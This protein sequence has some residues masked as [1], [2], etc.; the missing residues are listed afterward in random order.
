MCLLNPARKPLRR[1]RA[2][3]RIELSLLLLLSAAVACA[4]ANPLPSPGGGNPLPGPG[5]S[6]VGPPNRPDIPDPGQGTG[7]P[8][9]VK[10]DEL[11]AHLNRGLTYLS[12]LGPEEAE[13][14]VVLVGAQGA[15]T[16]EGVVRV[17]ADTLSEPL[18]MPT[19]GV[20]GFGGLLSQ[21]A[22]G[23]AVTLELWAVDDE[24]GEEEQKDSFVLEVRQLDRTEVEVPW[25]FPA[26][27]ADDPDPDASFGGWAPGEDDEDGLY[28][29]SRVNGVGVSP[30]DAS[31]MVRV[32]GGPGSVP[33]FSILIALHEE[34]SR[35]FVAQA[36][37][38]G[39]FQIT[40]AAAA[41]DTIHVF[42]AHPS[43]SAGTT[44][45]VVFVVPAEATP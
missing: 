35:S 5:T 16:G 17:A 7:S 36:V 19:N 21:V 23:T 6:E 15:A 24:S 40:L 1:G 34:S 30:P 4:E 22:A 41:G 3:H 38:D 8:P 28:N 39:S 27:D 26:G 18:V 14:S 43:D 32:A 10:H 12:A 44:D 2:R 11:G 31:G 29:T 20:G 25:I 45:A 42:A 9:D 37:S 13:G 33:S